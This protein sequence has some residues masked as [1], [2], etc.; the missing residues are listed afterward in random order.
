MTNELNIRCT[1]GTDTFVPLIGKFTDKQS[2]K[3]IILL[4]NFGVLI[5]QEPTASQ[6]VFKHN[7]SKN[8]PV[9]SFKWDS[10]D[11]SKAEFAKW[12]KKHPHINHAD[13]LNKDPQ[14]YFV[15]E[16]K[17]RQDEIQFAKESAKVALYN[18]VNNMDATELMEVSYFSMINPKG[19]SAL[20]LFN[21]LC[22]LNDGHLMQDDMPVKFISEWKQS[23]SSKKK[24]IR[25]AVL[26]D[27]IKTEAGV[28]YMNN[29]PIGSIDN[30]YAYFNENA[31]QFN[32]LKKEV[33]EIDVLPYGLAENMSVKAAIT[34]EK[35][36]EKKDR[37]MSAVKK[38]ENKAEREAKA[39]A[40]TER[41]NIQVARL[42]DLGVKGW[43]ASGAWSEEKRLEKIAEAD[44]TLVPA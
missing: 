40:E 43:Q 36:T 17:S 5:D 37:T 29:T 26:L 4:A 33:S 19:K 27:K 11:N 41:K 18:L 42:K 44:K 15:L 6:I 13:N 32:Y 35:V 22:G 20:N 21:E 1:H 39:H 16:D 8:N 10:D 28:F 23:D 14:T 38:D 30:L 3:K 9:F 34:T 7:F 25:K 24:V 2:R 31:E 12:L